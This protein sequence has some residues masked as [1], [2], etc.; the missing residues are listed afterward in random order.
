M[1]DDFE[2]APLEEEEEE[3]KPQ[4]KRTPKKKVTPEDAEEVI[5]ARSSKAKEVAIRNLWPGR[6]IVK[7]DQVPSRSV[8]E[9]PAV[10]AVVLVAEEDVETLLARHRRAGCCGAGQTEQ[11][12]F[13]LA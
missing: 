13:E 11:R 12:F 2:G 7:E 5:A 4:P 9:F 6:L 10:G 1:S 8:Y 3:V